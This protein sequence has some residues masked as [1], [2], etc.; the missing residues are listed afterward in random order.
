MTLDIIKAE[1]IA[2]VAGTTRSTFKVLFGNTVSK[3]RAEGVTDDHCIELMHAWG[4][5]AGITRQWVNA[6]LRDG[7]IRQR[8]ERVASLPKDEPEAGSSPAVE[9]APS[10]G[11]KFIK[12]DIAHLNATILSNIVLIAIGDRAAGATMLLDASDIVLGKP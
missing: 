2:G 9:V 10:G 3:L 6:C 12:V 4:R 7:G 11:E 1:F 5:E 8:R